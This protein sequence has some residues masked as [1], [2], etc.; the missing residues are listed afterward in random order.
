MIF[1]TLLHLYRLF[2]KTCHATLRVGSYKPLSLFCYGGVLF[3]VVFFCVFLFFCMCVCVFVVIVFVIVFFLRGVAF[4][5][6][7]GLF[8]SVVVFSGFF[9]LFV[10]LF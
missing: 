8:V 7:W 1:S 2:H 4:V 9:F 6:S 10:C 5:G 3:S